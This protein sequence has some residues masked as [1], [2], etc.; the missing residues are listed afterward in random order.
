MRN[1]SREPMSEAERRRRLHQC[2]EILLAVGR[3]KGILTTADRGEFG[4]QTR[5]AVSDA[6]TKEAG[7]QSRG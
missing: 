4:D 1:T 3:E 2:Y 7:A 6:Q 5:T